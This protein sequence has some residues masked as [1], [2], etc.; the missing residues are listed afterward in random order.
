MSAE[1]RWQDGPPGVKF[2]SGLEA[3]RIGGELMVAVKIA[4]VRSARIILT[5]RAP[6]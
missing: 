5:S 1:I 6:V 3:E 4:V 2:D